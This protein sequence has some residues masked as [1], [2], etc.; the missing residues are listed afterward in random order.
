MCSASYVCSAI[1][2]AVG[3]AGLAGR[4]RV[5]GTEKHAGAGYSRPIEKSRRHG[6]RAG[7]RR[8][9]L[10]ARLDRSR[11][12]ADAGANLPWR[13]W[14]NQG[15]LSAVRPTHGRGP[16]R[17]TARPFPPRFSRDIIT[18]AD[19]TPVRPATRLHLRGCRSRPR[20][21][22]ALLHILRI[23][24]PPGRPETSPLQFPA[25]EP[26]VCSP[27]VQAGSLPIENSRCVVY[28]SIYQPASRCVLECLHV[29]PPQYRT[30]NSCSVTCFRISIRVMV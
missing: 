18:R 25:G 10:R 16:P 8:G 4:M 3:N 14:R 12:V 17:S 28:Y 9:W 5:T 22:L 1:A 13:G 26:H 21:G 29:Q 23:S 2:E 27:Y 20:P 19:P 24:F 6:V 7:G 15:G 11:G 30:T